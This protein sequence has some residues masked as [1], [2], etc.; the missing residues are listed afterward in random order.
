MVQFGI[1][2]QSQMTQRQDCRLP[3]AYFAPSQLGEDA[4]LKN[5]KVFSSNP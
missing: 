4:I 1:N 2:R 5:E 3:A